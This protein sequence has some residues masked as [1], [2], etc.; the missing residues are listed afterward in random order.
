MFK[1]DLHK[2]TLNPKKPSRSPAVNTII[3]LISS[4]QTESFHRDKLQR[5]WNYSNTDIHTRSRQTNG[6]DIQHG[7]KMKSHIIPVKSEKTN[8]SNQLDWVWTDEQE[9]TAQRIKKKMVD[10]GD[11]LVSILYFSWKTWLLQLWQKSGKYIVLMV[12]WV[13]ERWE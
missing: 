9:L 10:E 3:K 13:A 11:D 1:K 8:H 6:S 12:G 5:E 2:K 4:C 7:I